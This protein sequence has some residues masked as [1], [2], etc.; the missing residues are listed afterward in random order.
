[1][2]L[3]PLLTWYSLYHAARLRWNSVERKR[4][5]LEDQL[6][7]EVTQWCLWHYATVRE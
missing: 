4:G 7:D 5:P 2:Q 1:M 6:I 3:F